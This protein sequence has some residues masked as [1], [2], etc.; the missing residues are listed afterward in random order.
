MNP[1]QI[2]LVSRDGMSTQDI[3]QIQKIQGVDID[4]HAFH[5]KFDT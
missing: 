2:D 4:Y 5:Y 1:S 3:E